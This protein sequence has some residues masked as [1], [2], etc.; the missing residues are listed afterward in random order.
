MTLS[1]KN[2]LL[3]I[4]WWPSISQMDS[5]H[6]RYPSFLHSSTDSG[7]NGSSTIFYALHPSSVLSTSVCSA[8]IPR[9]W[10]RV[11]WSNPDTL[12]L[13]KANSEATISTIITRLQNPI[14]TALSLAVKQNSLVFWPRQ[15]CVNKVTNERYEKFLSASFSRTL[16]LIIFSVSLVFALTVSTLITSTEVF[17]DHRAGSHLVRLIPA[18]IFTFLKKHPRQIRVSCYANLYTSWLTASSLSS[19][20]SLAQGTGTMS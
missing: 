10:R 5:G 16:Q 18:P 12:I 6:T 15:E 8:Y 2:S 14:P 9:S 11:S 20:W 1:W 4:C 19:Q 17:K 13:Q 3:R 7:N